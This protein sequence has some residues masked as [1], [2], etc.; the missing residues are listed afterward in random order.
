MRKELTQ[1]QPRW[2]NDKVKEEIHKKEELVEPV[3]NAMSMKLR[4]LS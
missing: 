4:V 2:I 3:T 1:F